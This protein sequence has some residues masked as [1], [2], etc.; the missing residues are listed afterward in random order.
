MVRILI[1]ILLVFLFEEFSGYFQNKNFFQ[2]N[3]FQQRGTF[4]STRKFP[5]LER[6]EYS[7][8]TFQL[9]RMT[10]KN[11]NYPI[12]HINTSGFG[13]NDHSTEGNNVWTLLFLCKIKNRNIIRRGRRSS[14]AGTS[15]RFCSNGGNRSN[16]NSRRS[17]RTRRS[18]LKES[19]FFRIYH[20]SPTYRN[21]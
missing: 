5:S 9:P 6:G 15:S 8:N 14:D 13:G 12:H 3:P 19:N 11:E 7:S 21:T 1:L 10:S 2:N 4:Q 17:R 18:V 16:R 20:S